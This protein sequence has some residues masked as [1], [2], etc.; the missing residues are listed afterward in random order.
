M[1]ISVSE[2]KPD[3]PHKPVQILPPRRRVLVVALLGLGALGGLG[4]AAW[5]WEQ[6]RQATAR[7][8]EALALTEEDVCIV[9]LPAPYNPSS[10][11]PLNAAR[12][13]P[14]DARCP[15]CGMYP[16]RSRAW[17]AQVIF[18][19][20]DAYFFDS[21]LSFF[22][23]LGNVAHYTKGREPQHI[24]AKY[25]TDTNIGTGTGAGTGAWLDATT[26]VYVTGSSAKG[27]MRAG[28]LP[29]FAS[30]ATAEKFVQQRGGQVL[31]FGAVDAALLQ[32]LAPARRHDHSTSL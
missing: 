12:E 20:G 26:A 1:G 30:K 31:E 27:P 16:S 13:V 25:V 4:G 18:E 5:Q 15:V 17:A 32:K 14:T 9:V 10:G 19:N 28:N 7:A 11:L 8:A 2:R 29:A 24:V 23:Y 6:N 22:M 21:P 3:K